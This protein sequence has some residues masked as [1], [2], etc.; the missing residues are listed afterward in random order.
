MRVRTSLT[1]ALVTEVEAPKPGKWTVYDI[2]AE[3]P[4]GHIRFWLLNPSSPFGGMERQYGNVADLLSKHPS[5]KKMAEFDTYRKALIFRN[6]LDKDARWQ[7]YAQALGDE[8]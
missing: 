6:K 3:T 7:K 5:A 2:G 8:A 1:E 4:L